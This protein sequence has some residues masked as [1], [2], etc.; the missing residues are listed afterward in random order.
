[1][2]PTRSRQNAR[3]GF[4]ARSLI[5]RRPWIDLILD[6]HK[7]LEMRSRRTSVRGRIGL[8]AAGTGLILGEVVLVDCGPPLS[9]QDASALFEHHRIDDPSLLRK[10]RYPW[11]LED[12]ARYPQPIPY[13]HPRGTVV[14]VKHR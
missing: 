13:K 14:W 6:G 1:M 9:A 10:W 7:T 8:I 12:A 5:I 3:E 2:S 11:R 4:P